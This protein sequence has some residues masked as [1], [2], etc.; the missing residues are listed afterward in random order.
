MAIVTMEDLLNR[1]AEFERKLERYFAEIRDVSEDKGVRLLTYY[2]ARHR[3]HLDQH[4]AELDA[5]G[6]KKI[7]KV[8]VKY[9]IDFH[10][11]R[12]L[13]LMDSQPSEIKSNELLNKAIAYD[14]QLIHLY[15]LMLEQPLGETA[16]TLVE[17]LIRLEEKDVVMLKKMLAMNYF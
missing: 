1:A 16:T 15:R 7:Y 4:L 8:K 11:E 9:D 3:R 5:D 14:E 12:D 6:R 13:N 10:P 17:A 2:L